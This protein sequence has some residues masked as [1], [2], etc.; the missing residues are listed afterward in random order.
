MSFARLPS[1]SSISRSSL[2][3]PS[4]SRIPKF[5]NKKFPAKAQTSPKKCP[6]GM[7]PSSE[8][9][10]VQRSLSNM[11]SKTTPGRSM[12]SSS[13]K[14]TAADDEDEILRLKGLI[15][16]EQHR[17]ICE[18][19]ELQNTQQQLA[20]LTTEM[21]SLKQI[22]LRL[23]D[24]LN[25][26]K[27]LKSTESNHEGPPD[28]ATDLQTN[29]IADI[30]EQ[31]ESYRHETQK[32][33]A[34]Y[35]E[36]N[37]Q[38]TSEIENLNHQLDV[39]RATIREHAQSLATLSQLLAIR[40]DLIAAMQIKEEQLTHQLKS[41]NQ[42]VSE[43]SDDWNKMLTAMLGNETEKQ[44]HHEE[45]EEIRAAL[46]ESERS[47]AVSEARAAKLA[48]VNGQLKLQFHKIMSYRGLKV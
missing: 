25:E 46:L 18:R 7:N 33:F 15:A 3:K 21:D 22:N 16:I 23:I 4:T 17:F 28:S 35:E 5:G 9:V 30:K 41:A 20:A 32:Q 48:D 47:L 39:G 37:V 2:S 13:G 29:E 45:I 42:V 26:A 19:I 27:T 14:P 31:L 12:G 34:A 8:K 40:T 6:I 38:Q 10:S 43:K 24:E 36:R 44:K 11:E 1:E